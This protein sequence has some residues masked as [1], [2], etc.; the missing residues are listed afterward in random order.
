MHFWVLGV[1]LV[2][3]KIMIITDSQKGNQCTPRWWTL[4]GKGE[5]CCISLPMP[6]IP[7]Y[8]V[9]RIILILIQYRRFQLLILMVTDF[10][11][12]SC[13][14]SN[15][16]DLDKDGDRQTG[17]RCNWAFSPKLVESN[18]IVAF[19][20]CCSCPWVSEVTRVFAETTMVMAS[21]KLAVTKDGLFDFKW[22]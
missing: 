4:C 8:I 15:Y 14:S 18:R 7:F 2:L 5:V 1:Q 13:P 20:R 3:N 19:T 12:S 9:L 6:H 21:S 10:S 11:C 22:T 16:K 17:L